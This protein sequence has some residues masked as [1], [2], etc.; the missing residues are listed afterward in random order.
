V[1]IIDKV[2]GI[3]VDF[4]RPNQ[5]PLIIKIYF[6]SINKKLPS[7][8]KNFGDIKCVW[9]DSTTK[10][11]MKKSISIIKHQKPLLTKKNNTWKEYKDNSKHYKKLIVLNWM[12]KLNKYEHIWKI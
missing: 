1:E 6:H 5:E 8:Y 7:S 12:N 2:E 4:L 10:V 3:P 11:Y 9:E